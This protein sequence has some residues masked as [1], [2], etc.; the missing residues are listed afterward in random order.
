MQG[1]S[2]RKK[3]L[4]WVLPACM[5]VLGVDGAT[6]EFQ[7]D[8]DIAPQGVECPGAP[9]SQLAHHNTGVPQKDLR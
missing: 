8:I 5:L 3:N 7:K 4:T 2:K 6:G 1:C 9:A